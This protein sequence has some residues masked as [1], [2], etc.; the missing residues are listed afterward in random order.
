MARRALE[1]HRHSGW[2]DSL[3]AQQEG[4]HSHLKRGADIES[5][6]IQSQCQSGAD[7]IRMHAVECCEPRP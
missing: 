3:V 5:L 2:D 6:I 4:S 7:A 1:L